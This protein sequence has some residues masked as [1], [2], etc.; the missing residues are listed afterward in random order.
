M[1]DSFYLGSFVIQNIDFRPSELQPRRQE[2]VRRPPLRLQQAG[3]AGRQRIRSS[4]CQTKAQI[5]TTH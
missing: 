1:T 2:A 5:V 3:Q 4:H